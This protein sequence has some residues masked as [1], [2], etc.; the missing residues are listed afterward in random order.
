M[1]KSLALFLPALLL[2]P[3]LLISPNRKAKAW[4]V[5]IPLVVVVGALL[6]TQWIHVQW[7][8][9][10]LSMSTSYMVFIGYMIVP[11][12]RSFGETNVELGIIAAGLCLLCLMSYAVSARSAVKR[13]LA[14]LISL[15]PGMLTLL[16][17][18]ARDGGKIWVAPAAYGI[19]CLVLFLGLIVA[20]KLCRK[21][22]KVVRFTVWFFVCNIVFLF[23]VRLA[24]VAALA[25]RVPR[26]RSQWWTSFVAPGFAWIWQGPT[27]M[28]C[29]VL[30]FIV[31]VFLSSFYRERLIRAFGAIP[32]VQPVPAVSGEA[33]N[34]SVGQGP[35][36]S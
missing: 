21:R 11:S 9:R 19:V 18:R 15:V 34:S 2:V 8:T 25:I 36:D 24:Y 27:A 35:S 1:V 22:L 20:G 4:L 33:V 16:A 28:F 13:T 17:L 7:L 10:A 6:A 26:I 14:L 12:A 29:M 3:P 31:T 5:L 30:P 32:V 23:V